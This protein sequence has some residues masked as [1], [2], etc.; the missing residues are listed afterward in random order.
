MGLQRVG[1]NLAI[2]QQTNSIYFTGKTI[3]FTGYFEK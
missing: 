3:Y 2:E 1:H